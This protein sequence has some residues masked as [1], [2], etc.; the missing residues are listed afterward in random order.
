MKFSCSGIDKI[1]R[2]P[3]LCNKTYK[4]ITKEFYQ[5]SQHNLTSFSVPTITGS[6]SK[7]N[8]RVR[9]NMSDVI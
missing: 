5:Y 8:P 3:L 1:Y 7:K 9:A 6:Y 4:E 2:N